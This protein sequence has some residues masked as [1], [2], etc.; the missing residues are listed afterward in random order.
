MEGMKVRAQ[1]VHR[2]AVTPEYGHLAQARAAQVE[3]PRVAARGRAV[4]R[5]GQR[6]VAD[7]QARRC[8]APAEYLLIE[9]HN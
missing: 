6:E 8:D 7:D 4:V 2:P 5:R 9:S 3:Q 1:G